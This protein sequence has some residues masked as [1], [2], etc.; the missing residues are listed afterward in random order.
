MKMLIGPCAG[1]SAASRSMRRVRERSGA[2]DSEKAEP[3]AMARFVRIA[4]F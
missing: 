4:I 3:R 1:K 2:L